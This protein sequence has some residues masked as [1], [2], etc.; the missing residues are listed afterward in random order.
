MQ[1]GSFN[2]NI[3]EKEDFVL[4]LSLLLVPMKLVSTIYPTLCLNFESTNF[5]IGLASAYWIR[6]SLEK[7]VL[8]QHL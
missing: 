3:T 5:L 4:V 2:Q 6:C 1:M 7:F 8:R